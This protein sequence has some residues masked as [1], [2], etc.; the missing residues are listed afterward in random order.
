MRRSSG[1][2]DKMPS[3]AFGTVCKLCDSLN[4]SNNVNELREL[5][6]IAGLSQRGAA[7]FL[8]VDDRDMRYYCSGQ[9]SIPPMVIY[10]MRYLAGK[11]YSEA[12]Q[13]MQDLRRNC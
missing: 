6:A 2:G 10:A 8:D 12:L 13:N 7:T 9:R 11:H 5:I 3:E 4:N 1:L